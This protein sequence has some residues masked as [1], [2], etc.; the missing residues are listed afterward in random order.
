MVVNSSI[1]WI[2]KS[3]HT[4]LMVLSHVSPTAFLT[5]MVALTCFQAIA[6][7]YMLHKAVKET[8]SR[9]VYGFNYDQI[10]DRQKTIMSIGTIFLCTVSSTAACLGVFYYSVMIILPISGV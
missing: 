9:I 7:N 5:G 8:L 6:V 3:I 4:Q 1:H 10:S 2:S